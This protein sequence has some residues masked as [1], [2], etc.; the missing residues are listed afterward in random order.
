MMYD[1]DVF[2]V[3]KNRHLFFSKTMSRNLENHDDIDCND[4]NDVESGSEEEEL[5]PTNPLVILKNEKKKKDNNAEDKGIFI[6]KKAL[7]CQS[8]I[9]I[10][11]WTFFAAYS[12]LILRLTT[13]N[14]IP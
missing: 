9:I 8:S 11:N 3:C 4:D 13:I 14:V 12:I 10:L 7:A 6:I 1:S 5:D 2:Q